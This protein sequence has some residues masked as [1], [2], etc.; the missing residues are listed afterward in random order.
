MIM[1]KMRIIMMIR[2]MRMIKMRTTRLGASGSGSSRLLHSGSKPGW[3]LSTTQTGFQMIIIKIIMIIIVII[4]IVIFVV[5][6]ILI[7]ISQLE[8]EAEELEAAGMAAEAEDQRM[9]E[10]CGEYSGQLQHHDKIDIGHC[11]I[12]DTSQISNLPP[13]Q[14]T[15][16]RRKLKKEMDKDEESYMEMFI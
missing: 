7:L 10:L 12:V 1:I 4:V 16:L 11:L 8:R 2:M 15:R 13:G 3:T 9:R 6:M 5:V 14:A